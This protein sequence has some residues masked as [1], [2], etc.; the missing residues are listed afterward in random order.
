MGWAILL[1]SAAFMVLLFQKMRPSSEPWTFAISVPEQPVRGPLDLSSEIVT[2]KGESEFVHGASAVAMPNGGLQA[3]WYRA[4]YEGAN[5]AEL[6]S[7]RFDGKEWSPT[8]VVTTSARVSHDLAITIKSLANPVPFRRSDKE[9]WLFFATSRLSGWATCEIGLIRSFDN[10]ATWGPAESLYATPFFNMSHLTKSTPFLFS[11]GRIGLP[12]YQEMNQKF[13]VLLV[14][15]ADGHVI[16]RRRMGKAGKVGYQPMIVATG[17]STAIAFVRPLKSR[18][19]REILITRT[20]DGGQTWTPVE[21]TN[22]PNPGGPISAIRY[23]ATHILMAFNDD[24]KMERNITLALADLDG[25]TFRRSGVIA[26]MDTDRQDHIVAYP[27]LIQ[28]GPGQFDVMY[29]RP[30]KTINHVRV[31]S[32]WIEHGLQQD[33]AQQ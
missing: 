31:S 3:F 23:D 26:R 13:P 27:F 2:P 15:D 32:T 8:H 11:D 28:S 19:P 29:S 33:T 4:P 10:G 17:P 1:C 24:A 7:A 6:V 30:I 16:D 14:L 22:L 12:V 9:I 21:P 18:R 20:T 5:D 25:K